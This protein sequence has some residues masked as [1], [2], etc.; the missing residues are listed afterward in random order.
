MAEYRRFYQSGGSYFF[1]V[2]TYNRM[3]ILTTSEN[4]SRLHQ[5]F[6]HVMNQ[7]SFTIE[8]MV[9]LPDHLHCIWQLPPG[10]SD[11]ST[12]W[13]LIK[14][15]FSITKDKPVNPVRMS[16]TFQLDDSHGA[17]N[18]VF[19][20]K[21][22]LSSS[23]IQAPIEAGLR[24]RQAVGF[25]NGVT[26][27][28]EKNIWQ[29]RF[30]EHFL[31]DEEDWRRHIDYIHYNPVKHG[32]VQNP[33]DWPHGSFQKALQEGLYPIGWGMKEPSFISDMNKE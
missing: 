31:R 8:A 27:R 13:R 20:L 24:T 23:P 3:P 15:Y 33:A 2:V 9:I 17:L 18:P 10:D 30:W 11:F 4:L 5:S 14:R 16:S 25:S 26:E 6:K 7:H 32:Y 1:T 19:A 22:I 29:R 12:R 28:G 21:G